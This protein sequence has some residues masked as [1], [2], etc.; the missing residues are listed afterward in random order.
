[1]RENETPLCF[2]NTSENSADEIP[3][4]TLSR[5]HLWKW[6]ITCI[7]STNVCNPI[8]ISSEG[9]NP[10]IWTRRLIRTTFNFLVTIIVLTNE[11]NAAIRTLWVRLPSTEGLPT[12]HD[13]P[14]VIKPAVNL[15]RLF[16]GTRDGVYM[17]D[18]C[19]KHGSPPDCRTSEYPSSYPINLICTQ[20]PM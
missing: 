12:G 9:G 15:G 19:S 13:P 8:S 5:G 2:R 11:S 3:E 1:M 7:H 4:V 17:Y 16:G 6:Y 20:Q 14:H 10:M 18:E